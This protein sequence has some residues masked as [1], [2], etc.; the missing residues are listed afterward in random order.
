MDSQNPDTG[1][2]CGID[3]RTGDRRLNPPDRRVGERRRGERRQ[4]DDGNNLSN[5]CYDI[6]SNTNEL[7]QLRDEIHKLSQQMHD[8]N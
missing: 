5:L 1:R 8:G 2:R 4:I 7:I 6:N 3:R